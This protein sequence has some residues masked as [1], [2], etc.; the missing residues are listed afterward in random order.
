MFQNKSRKLITLA[1]M[2]LM[3]TLGT[4]STA[5]AG[6]SPAPAFE[7]G[8]A[9]PNELVVKFDAGTDLAEVERTA[10]EMGG[11]V[12]SYEQNV[13]LALFEVSEKREARL[14]TQAA[15]ALDASPDVVAASPNYIYAI[16][17]GTQPGSAT[18]Y[19]DTKIIRARSASTG[20]PLVVKVDVAPPDEEDEGLIEEL[21]SDV[22]VIDKKKKGSATS[23]NND[24]RYQWGWE[25][26]SADAVWI[27]GTTAVEIAVLDTGADFAHPEIGGKKGP[28]GKGSNGYDW[29]NADTD[30]SDD[31]GHGT[32]VTGTA[33]AIANN[34]IGIAGVGNGSAYIVKVMNSQGW[35]TMF[36]IAL[37]LYEAADRDTVKVINMSLG[38][39][40]ATVLEDAVDY[41]VNDKG[42]LLV[43]SAGNDDAELDCAGTFPA[44]G[45]A[46]PACYRADPAF[47]QSIIVVAA[48]GNDDA[49]DG[50]GQ[51]NYADDFDDTW[52]EFTC[53]GALTDTGLAYSNYG[54]Y[55]DIIAPGTDILSTVPTTPVDGGLFELSS[56]LKKNKTPAD[57]P[58]EYFSGTSMAAPHVSGAAARAW[59]EMLERGELVEG[60]AGNAAAV[61]TRLLAESDEVF[62][63]CWPA[64]SPNPTHDR[65][66]LYMPG[67]MQEAVLGG[68]IFDADTGAQIGGV[69]VTAQRNGTTIASDTD[70]ASADGGLDWFGLRALPV[71]D[72][73]PV[74]MN[75]NKS[76]YTSGQ[77]PYLWWMIDEP[78][79]Y[80]EEPVSLP[81]YVKDRWSFVTN[82]YDPA[83]DM[84]GYLFLP[85]GAVDQSTGGPLDITWVGPPW[86]PAG[87]AWTS[88]SG[89]GQLA[90]DPYAR[91]MYESYQSSWGLRTDSIAFFPAY[92]GDYT[93]I[94]SAYDVPVEQPGSCFF[95]WNNG[96]MVTSDCI[97]NGDGGGEP[98]YVFGHV[99]AG[100]DS[101]GR[102]VTTWTYD[103][104]FADDV[105]GG[106]PYNDYTDGARVFWSAGDGSATAPIPPKEQ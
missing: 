101:K 91:I 104:V 14:R 26:I 46:F 83:Y 68:R 21:L 38:G 71:D 29:I 11:T 2:I 60:T 25:A 51:I 19:P 36:D 37:G 22:G 73:N 79:W 20:R 82:F 96:T 70:V 76:G 87:I 6:E 27:D 28:L 7:Q 24:P 32:H 66:F 57:G 106:T 50:D 93:Y 94:V 10:A 53:Q 30:P 75:V 4:A 56:I 97:Y 74:L 34:S 18:D 63:G 80:W 95:A 3:L 35:G 42:K 58:Y 89:D 105:G 41:A 47:D 61:K 84:D 49:G 69:A 12:I 65:P 100:L 48:S 67:A 98:L 40:H 43:V 90:V 72:I 64:S 5:L 54:G 23:R 52:A 9:V 13:G 39:P 62:D 99:T 33:V 88:N 8:D 31:N 16:P 92:V 1:A 55:V 85:V 45:T 17:N 81:P 15:T 59:A 77:Q 103:G 102:P 86:T 44:P 78:G